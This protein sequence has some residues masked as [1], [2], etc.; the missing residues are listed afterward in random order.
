MSRKLAAP[1]AC[2]P[3]LTLALARRGS[4]VERERLLDHVDNCEKCRMAIATSAR[5]PSGGARR[6]EAEGA[7]EGA[8][9]IALGD[10]IAEKYRI[11]ELIGSG[12]MGSVYRAHHLALRFDVANKVLRPE[13]LDDVTAERRFSREA[14]A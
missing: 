9:F 5:E 12:A 2:P 1:S 14:R 3:D 4:S 13:R 11:V 10:V 8:P 6:R 7:H